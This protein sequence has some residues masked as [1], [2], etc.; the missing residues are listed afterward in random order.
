M[1]LPIKFPPANTTI[2]SEKHAAT[3]IVNTFEPAYNNIV[4]YDTS[5]IVSY[6]QRYQLIPHC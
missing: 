6:T 4:L 5:P 3:Y 1:D 2:Q